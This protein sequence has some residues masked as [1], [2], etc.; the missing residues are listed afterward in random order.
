MQI[1][2]ELYISNFNNKFSYVNKTTYAILS[3]MIFFT[4][5]KDITWINSGFVVLHWISISCHGAK[6]PNWM[7]AITL[8]TDILQCCQSYTSHPTADMTTSISLC[9][10]TSL[11]SVSYLWSPIDYKSSAAQLPSTTTDTRFE[12]MR[13]CR[14]T[15]KSL[16]SMVECANRMCHRHR[17]HHSNSFMIISCTFRRDIKFFFLKGLQSGTVNP[18]R[19][20]I[21]IHPPICSLHTAW[22]RTIT[23]IYIHSYVYIEYVLLYI[24]WVQNL[25]KLT[26]E[27]GIKVI[28]KHWI[29]RT[30]TIQSYYNQFT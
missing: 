11:L 16:A 30:S 14:W 8:F 26:T 3:S 19:Y 27:G 6:C 20:C 13:F 28:K 23:I 17:K 18:N 21:T 10:H 29:Y 9:K 4:S 25:M 7:H 24:P 22:H 2:T 15:L 12:V 5:V 1:T